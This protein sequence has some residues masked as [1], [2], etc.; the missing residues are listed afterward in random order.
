M[1]KKSSYDD[2]LFRTKKC[3]MQVARQKTLCIEILKT[4]KNL[5]PPFMH[6]IFSSRTLNNPSRNPNNLNHF[7]LHHVTFGSKCLKAMGPQIW[8]C[9]PNEL[10]PADTLNSFK[11]MIKQWH[12]PSCKCNVC[13]VTNSLKV[14]NNKLKRGVTAI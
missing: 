7:R 8:N 3:T 5:N 9:L 10:K 14:N 11:R 4:I 2:L 6:S 12:G 1:I 13:N